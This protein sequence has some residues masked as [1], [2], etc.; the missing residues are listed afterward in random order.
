MHLRMIRNAVNE[1]VNCIVQLIL[2]STIKFLV[3]YLQ[4]TIRT[5]LQHAEKGA[6]ILL[7]SSFTDI[8]DGLINHDPGLILNWAQKEFGNVALDHSFSKDLFILVIYK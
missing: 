4:N 7:T 5:M 3:S 2:I 8:D 6:V 1:W